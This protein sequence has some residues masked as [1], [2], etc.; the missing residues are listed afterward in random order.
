MWNERGKNKGR[1]FGWSSFTSCFCHSVMLFDIKFCV[2]LTWKQTLYWLL[3]EERSQY[4]KLDMPQRRKCWK[5]GPK[6]KASWDIQ[7]RSFVILKVRR[8]TFNRLVLML[9][10]YISERRKLELLLYPC[11]LDAYVLPILTM[12]VFFIRKTLR[13]CY[14]NFQPQMPELQFLKCW[15]F[16]EL[17]ESCKIENS[18]F[19]TKKMMFVSVKPNSIKN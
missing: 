11:F 6:S 19:I 7:V 10:I 9:P 14:E 12:Q 4:T 2:R 8:I 16:L 15:F 1:G 17:F 5:E 3:L 18:V 13:K